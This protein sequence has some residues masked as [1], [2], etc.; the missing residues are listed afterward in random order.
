MEDRLNA[1]IRLTP[2]P[3]RRAVLSL[4]LQVQAGITEIRLRRDRPTTLTLGRETFYLTRQGGVT[5]VPDRPLL[6]SGEQLGEIFLSLC[7]RSVYARTEELRQGFVTYAGCRVG[8]AGEAVWEGGEVIGIR[9]IT[10]LCVRIAREHK[11]AAKPLLP[12]VWDGEQ[13]HATLLAAP[14]ACGKTTML[15]DLCRLLSL[16][17]IRV[18]VIDERG[19]LAGEGTHRFDLGGTAEVLTG[20]PKAKGMEQALRTLSPQVIVVDELGSEQE[21]EAVS[22]LFQAGVAVVASCH[23][24]NLAQLLRRPQIKALCDSGALQRLALL[25]SGAVGQLAA[26]YRVEEGFHEMAAG[27]DGA[28]LHH[29]LRSAAAGA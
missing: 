20:L 18:A 19:E 13:L 5:A 26:V 22:A 3:V 15:R 27:A 17:G 8:V 1:I 12:V 11:G 4:P 21:A 10:A 14:P 28:A 24:A 6:L 9:G 29:R 25:K 16:S 7:R 23:A 2:E